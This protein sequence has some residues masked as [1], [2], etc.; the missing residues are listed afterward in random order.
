LGKCIVCGV[1]GRGEKDF[2]CETCLDQAK[3]HNLYSCHF[4]GHFGPLPTP[5]LTILRKE[6]QET[7]IGNA[8]IIVI[9]NVCSRC[10]GKQPGVQPSIEVHTPCILHQ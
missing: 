6:C 3:I 5:I 2:L 8:G 1:Q 9:T 10:R 7:K 4:C